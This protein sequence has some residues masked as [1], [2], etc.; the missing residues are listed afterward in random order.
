MRDE[1]GG[2][3]FWPV[4]TGTINIEALEADRDQLFAE[5]VHLYRTGLP[6]WPD[7]HFERNHIADQQA[8]RYESDIWE[9]LVRKYLGGKSRVT[10]LEVAVHALHYEVQP[11][12]YF[13][14]EPRPA[15][16]TPINRL[17]TADQRRLAAVMTSLG[18]QQNRDSTERWWELV[19][20]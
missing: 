20:R 14:G 10:L 6:W 15:R 16:T 8:A 13:E 9:P 12:T 19:T 2:R 18:W 4:K 7:K 1:T 17:G 5:A 11:P 3:R